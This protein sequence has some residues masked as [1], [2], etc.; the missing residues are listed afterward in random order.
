MATFGT[1]Y[2]NRRSKQS[3]KNIIGDKMEPWNI[4]DHTFKFR[5]GD[6]EEKGGCTFIGGEWKDVTTNDLF[7]NKT[8]VMFSLPG[9]FTPT[10]SGEQLPS[11]DKKYQQFIDAGV[12]NVYCISVNDAFVMNAWARDLEIKNVTMIPDGCGTFTRSMGMLVNKPK[13]GFGMRSWRY[14]TLIKDGGIVQFFEEPGFNNFSN[15]DDPYEVSDP[16]TMLK[17]LNERI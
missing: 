16:D 15:D 10:C 13:Q 12:D 17:Y 4:M 1:S 7:K 11:Y 9:A 3:L 8:V 14:S 5:V 2:L 6:S